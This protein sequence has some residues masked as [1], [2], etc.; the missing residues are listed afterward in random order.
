MLEPKLRTR[1]KSPA[2]SV[3]R[4]DRQRCVGHAGDR[5]EYQSESKPLQHADP[6]D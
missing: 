2:A 1:L 4:R 5:H 3:N 6:H